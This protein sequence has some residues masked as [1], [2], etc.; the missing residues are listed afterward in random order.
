MNNTSLIIAQIKKKIITSFAV[1][2]LCFLLFI[3]NESSL[4]PR[5]HLTVYM[6]LATP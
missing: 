6:H 5:K 1:S 2:V 3:R 4:F